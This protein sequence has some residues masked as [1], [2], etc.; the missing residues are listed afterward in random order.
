MT[1]P[2]TFHKE[3]KELVGRMV[4]P[5]NFTG[6]SI[7]PRELGIAKKLFVK[8]PEPKFWAGFDL[9][10]QLN[11]L[12]WLLSEDGDRE[13]NRQYQMYLLDK[14]ITKTYNETQETMDL[15]STQP[16]VAVVAKPVLK[17][18]SLKEWLKSK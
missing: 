16:E 2:P 13:V 3:K 6:K 15:F 11:S 12:A 4:K 14:S 9:G 18:K 8:Y 1:K 10:F 5:E 17:P 7:W